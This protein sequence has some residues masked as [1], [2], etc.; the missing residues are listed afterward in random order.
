MD[1][2]SPY[3]RFLENISETVCVYDRC[4]N[5]WFIGLVFTCPVGNAFHVLTRN[6]HL[7][8]KSISSRPHI[9]P[10][11][12]FRLQFT[13]KLFCSPQQKAAEADPAK[14]THILFYEWDVWG[15]P[16]RP[17]STQPAKYKFAPQF[18][19]LCIFNHIGY[20]EHHQIFARKARP[21]KQEPQVCILE[22]FQLP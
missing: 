18:A 9:P 14:P 1:R 3:G 7:I 10:T 16:L 20:I 22:D 6:Y 12:I 11:R 2:T 13:E 21:K 5:H 4:L 8:A 19:F 17:S 15:Q